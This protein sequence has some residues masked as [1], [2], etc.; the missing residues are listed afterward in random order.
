MSDFAQKFV[1]ASVV[2]GA[3]TLV[4]G[5]ALGTVSLGFAVAALLCFGLAM[6][7]LWDHARHA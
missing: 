4:A 7:V 3:L 6:A 1:F 5:I 2:L